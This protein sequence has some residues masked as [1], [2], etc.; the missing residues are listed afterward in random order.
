MEVVES[1]PAM[2]LEKVQVLDALV[3]FISFRMNLDENNLTK[4][5]LTN[6]LLGFS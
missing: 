6:W 3:C 4:M 2:T 1:D 5:G